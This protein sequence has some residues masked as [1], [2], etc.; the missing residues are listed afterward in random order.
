MY[1]FLALKRMYTSGNVALDCINGYGEL[2]FYTKSSIAIQ[3]SLLGPS[4][5]QPRSVSEFLR[6]VST[7]MM[8]SPDIERDAIQKTLRAI[9]VITVRTE[10]FV[11]SARPR[12]EKAPGD[13]PEGQLAKYIKSHW[14]R[15]VERGWLCTFLPLCFQR[16]VT[17]VLY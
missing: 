17:T 14:F 15:V 8:T 5:S 3:I 2:L 16:V 4:P 13:M 11:C 10:L 7:S 6:D 12:R 1:F 9:K